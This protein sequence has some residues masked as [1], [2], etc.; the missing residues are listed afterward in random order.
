MVRQLDSSIDAC[1]LRQFL[2]AARIYLFV[3]FFS[4]FFSQFHRKRPS[5]FSA[6]VTQCLP[7][8]LTLFRRL[9][10]VS[11]LVLSFPQRYHWFSCELKLFETNILRMALIH[12]QNKK[13]R[14]FIVMLTGLFLKSELNL[15]NWKDKLLLLPMWHLIHDDRLV[16][17]HILDLF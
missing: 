8:P 3:F 16:A 17:L 4:L 9:K 7:S 13:I 11:L 10:L 1:A 5:I 2:D 15:L 14:I 12:L 6:L